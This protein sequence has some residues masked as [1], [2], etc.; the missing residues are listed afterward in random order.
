M[1][2]AHAVPVTNGPDVLLQL[3]RSDLMRYGRQPSPIVAGSIVKCLDRLLELPHF[4]AGPD[5]RCVLR[6]MRVYWRLLETQG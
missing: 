4:R 1:K 5:E 6:Q 2:I 3:L